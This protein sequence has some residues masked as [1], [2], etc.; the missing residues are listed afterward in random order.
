MSSFADFGLSLP[1][2]EALKDIQYTEPTPVQAK[3]IPLVMKGRDVIA[4]AETGSGKT[5]ACAIPVCDRVNPDLR[6][7]QALI[8]V[9]TRELALQYA[10]EVQRIG[11]KRGVK[12]F[13]LYGG[14]DYGL[15]LSKLR[16]GVQVLTATP[17]RLIDLVFRREVDLKHV[18]TLI[19]DE[20]DEMMSMGFQEDLDFISQCLV[21]EHQTLLFSA[22]M[23]SSIRK[24]S[25]QYMKDPIEVSLN[26]KVVAPSQVDHR[27]LFCSHSQREEQVQKILKEENVR[28]CI[29]FCESR[30]NV[31]KVCQFLRKNMQGVDFLHAGLSQMV[32]TI[33]TG[34]FRSGKIKYL[35]ATDV[36]AR[37]LDFSGVTHVI[38]HQLPRDPEVYVHRSGRTGRVGRS[39]K[40]ISMVTRQELSALRRISHLLKQDPVWIG[41]PPKASGTG[42]SKPRGK[43]RPQGKKGQVSK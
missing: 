41:P 22:T 17:G 10:T 2:L 20:A 37:G 43:R 27:F 15:Q 40:V 25:S 30:N 12:G 9:P 1:L 13:A 35:V 32:R 5:A 16:H 31:E 24:L 39:G 28:Q 29:I 11:E 23:P 14:E 36:A 4:L 6:E 42:K 3:A 38:M 19:L 18:E 21:H 8:L 34:K 33:V 7:I 26:R